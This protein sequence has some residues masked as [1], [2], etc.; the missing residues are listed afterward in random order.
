MLNGG[1]EKLKPA[2]P[3]QADERTIT[4]GAC[5]ETEMKIH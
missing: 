5:I 4:G 3:A 2:S 1:E